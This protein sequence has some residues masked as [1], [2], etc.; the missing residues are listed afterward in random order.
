[1]KKTG[2]ILGSFIVI[3]LGLFLIGSVIAQSNGNNQIQQ[4]DSSGRYN[5]TDCENLFWIDNENTG[6]ERK[7]FLLFF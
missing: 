2:L 1:M 7:E 3:L 5:E 4:G 6:C